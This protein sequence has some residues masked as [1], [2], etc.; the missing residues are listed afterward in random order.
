MEMNGME[1]VQSRPMTEETA[2]QCIIGTWDV[3]QQDWDAAEILETE[4]HYQKRR[5]LE[6]IWM[7]KTPQTCNLD[8]GLILDQAWTMHTC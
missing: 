5:V 2:L 1:G 7:Q 6:A 3:H 4:S 8:C